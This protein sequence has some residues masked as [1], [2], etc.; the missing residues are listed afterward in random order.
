MTNDE[1]DRLA[2]AGY[3][4][5]DIAVVM[6]LI[7]IELVKGLLKHKGMQSPHEGY[8]V[9]LEEVDELWD[10]VKSDNAPNALHEVAQVGAMAARF[11]LDLSAPM[12]IKFEGVMGESEP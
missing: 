1:L 11:L 6:R 8:A 9:I 7:E 3:N 10:E 4:P 12:M 5:D 2:R